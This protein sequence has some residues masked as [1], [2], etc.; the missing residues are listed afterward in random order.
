MILLLLGGLSR[1]L[2]KAANGIEWI[3]S[4]ISISHVNDTYKM[5]P[6][7]LPFGTPIL[8]TPWEGRF[9]KVFIILFTTG[10]KDIYNFVVPRV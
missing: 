4:L 8:K 6:K 9:L 1:T 10:R 7:I 3:Q 2:K 5:G